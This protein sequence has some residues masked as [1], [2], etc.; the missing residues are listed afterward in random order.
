MQ[1]L[2]DVRRIFIPDPGFVLVEA[3]LSGADAYT[4]AKEIGGNF[5]KDFFGGN[6]KHTDT[7]KL[8]YPETYAKLPKHEP[9]YT[10]CKNMLYGS[11]YVGSSKGIAAQAG[12]PIPIVSKFQPWFFGK[13]P[14]VKEWHR[15]VEMELMTTREIW[16]AFDYRVHCFDRIDGLLPEAVNWKCQST[17][18]IV[19]QKGK[20]ILF[21]EFKD[22]A[23]LLLDVHDS[24]LFQVRKK[25]I[26]VVLPTIR[27][28][29]DAI[30]IPYPEPMFIPWSFKSSAS[31]WGEA[32]S[33]DWGTLRVAA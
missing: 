8:C 22:E 31:S 17:T 2:P 19:C 21:R 5:A 20:V 28:R 18:S 11:I 16:N 12:I 6:L 33:I 4:A 10:K 26:P 9:E 1:K 3:D 13:Y 29:L 15:K 27:A 14:E 7:M 25:D 30:K 23:Q 24:L 32:T